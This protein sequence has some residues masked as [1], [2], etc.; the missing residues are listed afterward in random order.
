MDP[1]QFEDASNDDSSFYKD[2]QIKKKVFHHLNTIFFQKTKM[3]GYVY[4]K[5]FDSR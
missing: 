4:T 2:D 5:I 1:G 3:L